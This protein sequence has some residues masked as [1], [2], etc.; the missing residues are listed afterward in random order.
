MKNNVAKQTRR[1]L[2]PREL[3]GLLRDYLG[4]GRRRRQEPLNSRS[5]L[6]RFI[7]TRAS[8]VAQTSL[9]GYLRTRAGQRYP[10]LFE[11]DEFVGSINI[12]KWHVWLA[13][14]SDLAVYTGGLLVQRESG[15]KEQIAR[16]ILDLVDECITAAGSP[17]D[18]GDE[19][20]AH[21][22]A[23]RARVADCRWDSVTDDEGPF[24]ESPAALV[25]WA[26]IVEEL[27]QLDDGIVR[28]SVRFRWQEIRRDLRRN[29]D[30]VAVLRE[31]D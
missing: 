1:R 20:A 7:D 14:L 12:A 26:P 24:S 27:K 4:I 11:S 10:E 16:L 21:A 29:L 18:A 6:Q 15:A 22:R 23:V 17:D 3:L 9:Y 30:A 13:C 31:E 25:Q 2:T 8:F 28:N 5:S 19:F